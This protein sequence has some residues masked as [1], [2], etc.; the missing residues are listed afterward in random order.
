[1]ITSETSSTRFDCVA[2]MR[3]ARTRISDRMTTMSHEEFRH[4]LRSYRHADPALAKL[5]AETRGATTP[6]PTEDS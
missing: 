4:W 5:A 6:Q 2:Y 1:M 3:E